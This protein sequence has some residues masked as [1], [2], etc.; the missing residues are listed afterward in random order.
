MRGPVFLSASLEETL[1]PQK[2]FTVTLQM[3]ELKAVAL[4]LDGT[5]LNPK[6]EISTDTL[7]YL[8]KRQ[9][10]GLQIILASGRMTPRI[11]PFAELIGPPITVIA[12]NG[13]RVVHW[14][15]SREWQSHLAF[16]ITPEIRRAVLDLCESENLFL[17]MYSQ[18]RLMGYH[19]RGDYSGSL[20]YASQTGAVYEGCYSEKA[21]TP[22]EGLAKLL[23]ITTPERR[24]SLFD[25]Y[26]AQ[27]AGLS[28]VIKSNPE[29]LEF[30]PLH[31][32]KGAALEHWL[33]LQGIAPEQVAAF[34]DAEN[35]LEM[36]R[37]VGHGIAVA[38]ASPGLKRDYARISAFAHD[39]N[40]IARELSVL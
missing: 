17:N 28:N 16:Q 9:A 38:N 1:A 6:G 14:N 3:L 15:A 30:M 35:D 23:V 40:V 24:E 21:A 25:Q 4:D 13:A 18:D 39:D 29:Y 8:K 32:N 33:K 34:G 10:Q 22:S 36:L 7:A 20:F 27:F 31:V 12:Y 2:D 26:Q 11:Q 37:L 5:L 19:P